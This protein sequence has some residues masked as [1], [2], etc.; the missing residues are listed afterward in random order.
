LYN[1]VS[2]PKVSLDTSADIHDFRK[3]VHLLNSP[4]FTGIVPSQILVYK[5]KD[6]FDKRNANVDEEKEEPLDE[7]TFINGLGASKK[8]TYTLYQF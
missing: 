3:A 7:N 5:N 6:A 1:G 8:K 2:A 4:I